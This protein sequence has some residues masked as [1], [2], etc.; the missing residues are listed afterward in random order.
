[1][2]T[3]YEDNCGFTNFSAN[4]AF[5]NYRT[6][7][8]LRYFYRIFRPP[9][10][11]SI[12]EIP[13]KTPTPQE[14]ER[15]LSHHS[16][17]DH[18]Y[19]CSSPEVRD[20]IV[21]EKV[22]DNIKIRKKKSL[23]K[24]S[25]KITLQKNLHNDEYKVQE[26][27]FQESVL[28]QEMT[29]KEALEVM[30][31]KR[32]KRLKVAD[33]IAPL[34][35]GK[36]CESQADFV[37]EILPENQGPQIQDFSSDSE[38]SD[39]EIIYELTSDDG[40]KGSSNDINKLWLQVFEAVS[41]ARMLHGLTPLENNPLGD[42]GLQMLGLT[43]S[44]VAY[45]V[46]QLP[47]AR[48]V[49]EKY[50]FKHHRLNEEPIVLQENPSG[51]ARGEPYKDRKP[52]DMFSWLASKH[53]KRPDFYSAGQNPE[54]EVQIAAARRATSLDLPMAMRFRHLAKNAKEAVGVYRSVIHGRGLFC[55][56]EIQVGEMVIEYAGELIRA[57]LTDKR[58]KFY[59][60]RGIGCYMFKIDDDTVV[61]ATMRGNA[62]RFI[63]HS[64]DVS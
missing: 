37:N 45:L 25:L 50:E 32:G 40:F 60:S 44:A 7:L 28:D 56:R 12:Q 33:F 23:Q 9:S 58:E 57:M 54:T 4:K 34:N 21:T 53:R 30:K 27:D 13:A 20:P 47:G 29:P 61:D 5:E 63:N 22:V 15:P 11:S 1:M 24:N 36:I 38:N 2:K 19:Y 55:K 41:E 62:A 26:M 51:A 8:F 48:E 18:A 46:E 52:L 17:E 43:H 49:A 39:S 35:N 14:P 31:K 3:M 59:E 6:L 16:L 64:C 10:C 42:I